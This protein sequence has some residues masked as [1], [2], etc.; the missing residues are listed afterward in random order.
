MPSIKFFLRS[1]RAKFSVDD[2]IKN[3]KYDFADIAPGVAKG[4]E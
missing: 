2:V 3:G 4:S 1:I